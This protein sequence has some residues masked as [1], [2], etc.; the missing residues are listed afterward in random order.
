MFTWDTNAT[1]CMTVMVRL[2]YYVGTGHQLNLF[3]RGTLLLI[4][5][6]FS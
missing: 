1:S 5:A 4:V 3:A 2:V 6:A